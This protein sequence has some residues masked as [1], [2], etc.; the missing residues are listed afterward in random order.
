MFLKSLGKADQ[1]LQGGYVS[2]SLPNIYSKLKR[3]RPGGSMRMYE[4]IPWH[5]S[6]A[7]RMTY[8]Y[9]PYQMSLKG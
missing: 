4:H 9:I 3:K 6:G 1:H 8:E 5:M 2:T 7:S